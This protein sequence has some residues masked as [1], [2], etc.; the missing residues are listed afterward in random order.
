[1][2][3]KTVETIGKVAKGIGIAIITAIP[4]MIK[5]ISENNQKHKS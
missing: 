4:I 1:M 3:N 5:K 2:D